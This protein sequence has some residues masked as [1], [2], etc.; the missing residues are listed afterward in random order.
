M[1]I[2][3]EDLCSTGNFLSRWQS[4]KSFCNERKPVAML[5]MSVRDR[6]ISE[7]ENKLAGIVWNTLR[8]G[9]YN[10]PRRPC[11][12]GGAATRG[13]AKRAALNIFQRETVACF[14]SLYFW[15]SRVSRQ[16]IRPWDGRA[17]FYREGAEFAVLPLVT[18]K[19]STSIQVKTHTQDDDTIRIEMWPFFEKYI[20]FWKR[21]PEFLC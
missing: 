11:N 14:V 15:G 13:S 20:S 4:Q 18:V 9:L 7:S 2:V 16:G 8:P 1:S 17:I 21:F 5:F 3:P 10:C 12:G 6:M 19:C